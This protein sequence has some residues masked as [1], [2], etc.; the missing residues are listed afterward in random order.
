MKNGWV[1]ASSKGD[2][3]RKHERRK[4]TAEKTVNKIEAQQ[5]VNKIEGAGVKKAEEENNLT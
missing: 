1:A 5:A 4:A 3:D 2:A